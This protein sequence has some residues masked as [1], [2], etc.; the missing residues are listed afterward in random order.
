M[1]NPISNNT[2]LR[3]LSFA[4]DGLSLRQK[5]TAQNIAN[6]DTPNYKA[7]HVSFE[8][9]LQQALQNDNET[10]LPVKMTHSGHIDLHG[11]TFKSEFITLDHQDNQLRNDGNN[12]DIDQEMTNLPETSLR[13]Q[14]LTQLAGMKLSL[15]KA[16][17][18]EGR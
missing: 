12:V 3:A 7:Q 9:Q 6:V 18:R 10:G 1:T 5:A 17:I 13:Y 8:A 15:L 14:S 4:L 2:T 16:I 11:A